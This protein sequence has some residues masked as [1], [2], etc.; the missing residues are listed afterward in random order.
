MPHPDTPPAST[1]L[2]TWLE[3]KEHSAYLADLLDEINRRIAESP[4]DD[5]SFRVG[6]SYFM[7]KPAHGGD[8]AL[9]RLWDTQI[10]PLLTEYHWGDGTAV[11]EVYGLEEIRKHLATLGVTGPAEPGDDTTGA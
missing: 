1:V 3:K 2:R 7:Q 10:L 4:G 11:A 5:R 8:S 9:Q 6:H